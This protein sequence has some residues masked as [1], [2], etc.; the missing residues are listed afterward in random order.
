MGYIQP[1]RGRRVSVPTYLAEHGANSYSRDLVSNMKRGYTTGT[2]VHEIR[3]LPGVIQ[4]C[5]AQGT[6][7]DGMTGRVR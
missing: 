2:A 6:D 3:I 7:R 1:C 4:V 5:D